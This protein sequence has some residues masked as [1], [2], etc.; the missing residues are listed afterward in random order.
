MTFAEVGFRLDF[1]EFLFDE[2]AGETQHDRCPVLIVAR[3]LSNPV[4]ECFCSCHSPV[5]K[6]AHP[7]GVPTTYL[8]FQDTNGDILAKVVR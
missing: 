6:I 5:V 2:C 8:G 3:G 7:I 1:V 4:G